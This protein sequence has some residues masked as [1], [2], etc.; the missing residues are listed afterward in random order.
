MNNLTEFP[1]DS[2]VT[3]SVEFRV[4]VGSAPY[5]ADHGFQDLVV[6][7]G[8][9][10]IDTALQLYRDRF[11]RNPASVSNVTFHNPILLSADDIAVTVEMTDLGD[12]RVGYAFYETGGEAGGNRQYAAKMEISASAAAT[13]GRSADELSIETFRARSDVSMDAKRFYE[14]VRQNG[15]QYGPKFQNMASIWRAGDQSLGRLSI[16]AWNATTGHHY[17]HPSVLDA[18]A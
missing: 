2:V 11:K 9:Y 6:L 5:L 12:G 3:S 10:Y 18:M 16:G 7:P 1:S 15:N 8:S 4:G 17:I 13:A 14:R